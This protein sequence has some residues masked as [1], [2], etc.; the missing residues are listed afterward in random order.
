M[1]HRPPARRRRGAV[2][3]ETA[4]VYPAMV[5][6]L[7]L[8][9][10]GG[11]GVHRYQQVACL[12]REAARWASV[13]GTDY[14]KETGNSPPT[15]QEILQKAVLP[16]ATGMDPEKLTLQVHWID[17]ATGE[18]VEWDN[19][20]KAPATLTA[21]DEPVASRLRVTVTYQW[22]P[23]LLLTGPLTLRSVAEAPMTF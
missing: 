13:R 1:T 23:E 2:A 9:I 11:M 17:S 15:R 16:L 7:L 20:A 21:G 5:F 22:S 6:L 14:Q 10:V 8:L 18:V 4:I 3:L 12:A 19:S